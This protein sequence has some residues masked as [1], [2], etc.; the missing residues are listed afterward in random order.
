MIDKQSIDKF[1]QQRIPDEVKPLYAEL[2]PF[3]V[4]RKDDAR[5]DQKPI[6]YARRLF[7]KIALM[8]G[9]CH[10]HYADKTITV[11]GS[12]LVFSN[13]DT[14][15]TFELVKEEPGGYFC[16][17]KEDFF[18]DYLR[19]GLREL[20]KYRIGGNPAF[21]IDQQGSERVSAVFEKMLEEVNSDYRFKNDLLRNYVMEIIHTA[22][23]LQPIAERD[24]HTDANQRLTSVFM[25]L[26]ERQFPVERPGQS[27]NMKSAKDF[28]R[29]LSVHVNHLNRA[30][31]IT[32]G[33]TTSAIIHDRLINEAK[34]LLK[35][36]D[37]N[38]SEIGFSLGFEDPSHFNHFFRKQTNARPSDYRI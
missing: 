22:L 4:F 11:K 5:P 2:G 9:H 17:F 37:W 1:Y 14:P 20:P 24:G 3:N 19:A 16:I 12:A 30:V 15:Y 18:S 23:K 27:F 31:K 35:H 28:A 26:L 38:V 13:P 36:T 29:Q 7:F 6:K 8:H 25:E 33:K 32:T 34:A 10:F 21:T